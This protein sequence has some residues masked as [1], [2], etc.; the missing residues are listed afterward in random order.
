MYNENHYSFHSVLKFKCIVFGSSFKTQCEIQIAR[1]GPK[2]IRSHKKLSTV[3]GTKTGF[4][5]RV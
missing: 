2:P 1:S 3:F 5:C 4:S